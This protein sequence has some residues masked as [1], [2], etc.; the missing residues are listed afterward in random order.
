MLHNAKPDN[1]ALTETRANMCCEIYAKFTRNQCAPRLL[2]VPPPRA[3]SGQ[4][5][6]HSIRQ[7][8]EVMSTYGYFIPVEPQDAHREMEEDSAVD[9]GG[10]EDEA[11]R[12]FCYLSIH[13]TLPVFPR[14]NRFV[15][16]HA[17][18]SVPPISG[19]CKKILYYLL[20]KECSLLP[21]MAN[22]C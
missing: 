5:A 13:L 1:Y 7:V 15:T 4:V 9:L 17:F 3:N 21:S 10:P 16:V 8:S 18:I 2:A 20:P 6:H 22:R 14:V 12:Q 11:P 19:A